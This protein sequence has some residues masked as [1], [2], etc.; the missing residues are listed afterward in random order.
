MDDVKQ[1][2]EAQE[3]TLFLLF[4]QERP[5]WSWLWAPILVVVLSLAATGIA[6]LVSRPLRPVPVPEYASAEV[7][8]AR[9][10]PQIDKLRELAA[11]YLR[12]RGYGPEFFSAYDDLAADGVVQAAIHPAPDEILVIGRSSLHHENL[13]RP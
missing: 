5:S 3:P 6:L 9:Y 13:Q 12:K 10:A 7:I 11:L 8:E 4:E 2:D 1:S